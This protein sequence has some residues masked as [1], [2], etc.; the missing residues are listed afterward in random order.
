MSAR[1]RLLEPADAAELA[2]LVRAN[3]D[4]LAPYDPVRPDSHY[5]ESGQRRRIA[6]LRAQHG[7]GTCA[8]F[9]IVDDDG[10][11]AGCVTL[12]GIVRGPLQSASLGYWVAEDRNGRG[13]AAAAV[14]T[15][16]GL[17]FQELAL[18]RVEAGTLVDNVRSQRVLARNG[19]ERYGL[20]PRYLKIAG[21]WRDHV[22]FQ[23][24]NE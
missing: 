22:L 11:I 4:F 15:T 5:T 14:A 20:A 18:H 7:H 2:A 6:E 13:L 24:L 21:R 16:V 10:S 19:F 17:A 9:A 23:R 12:S 3:R 1:I 8:P